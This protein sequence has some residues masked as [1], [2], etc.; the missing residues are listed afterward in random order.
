MAAVSLLQ[1]KSRPRLSPKGSPLPGD[2]SQA[3]ADDQ[4]QPGGCH[5]PTAES[6]QERAAVSPPHADSLAVKEK[7]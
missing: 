3:A 4:I 1:A 7:L 2:D 6:G 5:P